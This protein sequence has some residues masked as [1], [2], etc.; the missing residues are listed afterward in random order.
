MKQVDTNEKK[1]TEKAKKA[2]EKSR[3]KN[4]S[5]DMRRLAKKNSNASKIDIF[6]DILSDFNTK[7]LDD[8]TFDQVFG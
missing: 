4:Q 3:S 5:L 2:C 8:Q 1:L 7:T 6:R